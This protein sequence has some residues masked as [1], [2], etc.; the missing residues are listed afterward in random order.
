MTPSEKIQTTLPTHGRARADLLQ[1]MAALRDDDLRWQDGRVFSL[2]FHAGDEASAVIK[3]AYQMFMS[4][5]GLNPGAFPSLRRF[6]TDVVQISADLLGGN[7]H[8]AGN[9]TSGG[10]ESI[11]MAVFTAREW[12]RANF[13]PDH[14]RH[15]R[16]EIVAP[17]TVHPAFEKAAHYFDVRVVHVQLDE[18]YRVDVTAVAEAITPATIMLVGSAPAYPHGVVDPIPDLAALAQ[19]HNLL[20]HVDACVGGFILPFVRRLGYPVT[21]FDFQV[22]GVTSIS[23][24]LHKYAYAAKGASVILYRDKTL[25]RHQM[26]AYMDWPG[27]IY[28]SPTMAGTRPGGAIAAAWAVLHHLGEEG[29]MAIAEQVMAASKTLQAGINAID[30]LYVPGQPEATIFAIASDTLNIYEVGDEMGERGWQLDRQQFPATLHV[31]LNQVHLQATDRFLADLNAAV[32]SAKR[33][34]VHKFINWVLVGLARLL[35]VMLP[36]KWVSALME[37]VS[38]LLGGDVSAGRSAAMYGL[39]G[40]LPNRGD[41]REVVLDLLSSFTEP[42]STAKNED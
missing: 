27:G 32:A 38:G 35:T 9:M 10:T 4:E 39:M 41:L 6:E 30:E 34:S 25:R 33:P 36:D 24:D 20:C 12:A 19:R 17:V 18:S 29:Y 42:Q 21:P 22:P 26:F 5:N 15:Q 2:V 16:P 23:A 28:A 13:P 31:T 11:L 14:P 3:E 7:R 37:R 8:T 40:S 1:E